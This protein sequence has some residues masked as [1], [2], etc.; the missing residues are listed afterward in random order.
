MS[1]T[2]LPAESGLPAESASSVDLATLVAQLDAQKT[3]LA[4][5]VDELVAQRKAINEQIKAKR[6]EQADV[7]RLWRATQP[8]ATKPAV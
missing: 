5:E 2:S 3:K 4:G 7:E 8:R 1:D 6:Q